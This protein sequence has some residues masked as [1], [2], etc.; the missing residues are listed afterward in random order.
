MQSD[1]INKVKK[2][3]CCPTFLP[4][5]PLADFNSTLFYNNFGFLFVVVVAVAVVVLVIAVAVVIGIAVWIFF[6]LLI[7]QVL[8]IESGV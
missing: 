1:T 4:F 5:H 8:C 2:L 6:F 3:F 7:E